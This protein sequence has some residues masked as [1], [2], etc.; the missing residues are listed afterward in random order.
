MSN[1]QLTFQ[2]LKN[3]AFTAD[4]A[5]AA[6]VTHEGISTKSGQPKPYK[7]TRF[8]TDLMMCGIKVGLLTAGD[9]DPRPVLQA[10]GTYKLIKTFNWESSFS[11]NG[12]WISVK[13]ADLIKEGFRKFYEDDQETKEGKVHHVCG[14]DKAIDGVYIKLWLYTNQ[15]DKTNADAVRAK[16]VLKT[17]KYVAVVK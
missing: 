10:D 16:L 3:L 4:V 1:T 6:K 17:T 15:V 9:Y 2:V 5:A 7:F 11:K 8:E 14:Y 12:E 13:E